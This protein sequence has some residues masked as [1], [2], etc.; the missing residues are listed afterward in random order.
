MSIPEAQDQLLLIHAV[1]LGSDVFALLNSE[2]KM[3]ITGVTEHNFNP[4]NQVER[5]LVEDDI[6]FLG[7]ILDVNEKTQSALKSAS[8]TKKGLHYII[9]DDAFLET[10]GSTGNPMLDLMFYQ[11]PEFTKA[12]Q[13]HFKKNKRNI[14]KLIL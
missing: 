1:E 4:I 5:L 14:K 12:I 2:G 9:I 11:N 3:F 8:T 10:Q 7:H 6:F 13:K